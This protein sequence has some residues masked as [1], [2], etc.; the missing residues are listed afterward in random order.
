MK[1]D[2]VILMNLAPRCKATSKRSGM[3]CRAPA[4]RGWRVCR[5][6]GARG[7]APKGAGN[8]RYVH[9]RYT[10]QAVEQRQA[11]ALLIRH[12]KQYASTL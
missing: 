5:F 11:L 12:S 10:C 4:V 7:G 3:S 1:I 2:P 6:H 9:G 8:G